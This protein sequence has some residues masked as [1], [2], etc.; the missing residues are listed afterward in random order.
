MPAQAGAN[1]L[2]RPVHGIDGTGGNGRLATG[3]GHDFLR[4]TGDGFLAHLLRGV[5]K[6]GQF[7]PPAWFS[8]PFV[9]RPHQ[10]VALRRRQNAKLRVHERMRDFVEQ[11][12]RRFGRGRVEGV[13]DQGAGVGPIRRGP[14]RRHQ[15]VDQLQAHRGRQPR[16]PHQALHH[17]SQFLPCTA[18]FRRRCA[19]RP[20]IGLPLLPGRK[21]A[22]GFVEVQPALDVRRTH[23]FVDRLIRAGAFSYQP[24]RVHFLI[25]V[26]TD[27]AFLRR[28]T[29][30]GRQ[31]LTPDALTIGGLTIFPL[32]YLGCVLGRVDRAAGVFL[33]QGV[34]KVSHVA[35]GAFAVPPAIVPASAEVVG[36][37]L[38]RPVYRHAVF[39]QQPA[40]ALVMHGIQAEGDQVAVRLNAP[41]ADKEVEQARRLGRAFRV[42]HW[43]ERCNLNGLGKHSIRRGRDIIRRAPQNVLLGGNGRL[44]LCGQTLGLI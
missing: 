15:A 36:G 37:N 28:R 38:P 29:G 30:F 31:F 17:D 33:G 14:V 11:L 42:A 26:Q 9:R 35:F 34:V 20:L 18:G 22:A 39:I 23:G 4:H 3:L 6:V 41:L 13:G 10:G 19:L 44:R 8:K 25:G 16:Q 1:R 40:R 2:H 32:A 21:H 5:A 27:A 24:R 7:L 43:G 12:D